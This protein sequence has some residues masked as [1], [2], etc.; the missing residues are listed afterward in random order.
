MDRQAVAAC[1]RQLELSEAC[2]AF[3]GLP[4]WNDQPEIVEKLLADFLQ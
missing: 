2:L 1:G 3:A 4:A